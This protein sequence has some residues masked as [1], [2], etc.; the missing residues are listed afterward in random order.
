MVTFDEQT[1]RNIKLLI[2]DGF[3]LKAMP[4]ADDILCYYRSFDKK[5]VNV[6]AAPYKSKISQAKVKEAY[7]RFAEYAKGEDDH[8]KDEVGKLI[9]VCGAGLSNR[10][11]QFCLLKKVF[12]SDNSQTQDSQK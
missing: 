2:N 5:L 7:E 1:L 3:A 11:D 8:L 12:A 4:K 6:K 9:A 10:Q